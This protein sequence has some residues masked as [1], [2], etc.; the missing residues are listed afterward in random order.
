MKKK[1]ID[2]LQQKLLRKSI[3]DASF[4]STSYRIHE[5][6][7]LS[8]GHIFTIFFDP[9]HS[10]STDIILT[11]CYMNNIQMKWQHTRTHT[12]TKKEKKT[13]KKKYLL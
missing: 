7:Q 8:A 9:K 2:M 12:H 13:K 11:H 10:I 6:K 1:K 5:L 4:F 3:K